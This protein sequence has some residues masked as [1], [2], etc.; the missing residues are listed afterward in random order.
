MTT[1]GIV[2]LAIGVA[3]HVGSTVLMKLYL[4]R[5]AP[6]LLDEDAAAGPGPDG[7]YGWER[8]AGTGVVPRWVSAL[9]LLSI[10]IGLL[11]VIILVLGLMRG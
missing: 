10:P 5:R 6:G 8:T 4:D 2:L 11:G 3:L 7:R 1:L 9:G